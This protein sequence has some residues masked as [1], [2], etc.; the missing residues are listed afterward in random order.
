M[1]DQSTVQRAKP[2]RNARNREKDVLPDIPIGRRDQEFEEPGA[3]GEKV[4][5]KMLAIA[6]Q[7]FPPVPAEKQE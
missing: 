2:Q 1:T 7:Y 6:R 3:F 5:E 4:A